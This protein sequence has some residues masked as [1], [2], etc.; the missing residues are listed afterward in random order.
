MKM[1][2]RWRIIG[3]VILVVSIGLGSLA[4]IS[5]VVI[6]NKTVDAVVDQSEVLVTQVSQTMTTF[7]S[8]YE[9]S[10]KNMSL[11][12]AVIEFAKADRTYGGEADT[13]YRAELS[14]FMS[15]FPDASSIYFADASMVTIEP[16]FDGVKDINATTRSWYE[17]SI[18]KPDEVQWTSPYIDKATGN[19]TI[20][21]SIAVKENNHIIGVLGVDILLDNLTGMVSTIELGYDGIPVIID[22]GGVAIVHPSQAGNDISEQDAVQKLIQAQENA[23]S[24]FTSIDNK[25]S[26]V[27]FS[28]IPKI[29]WNIGAIYDESKLNE[30]A[31]SIQKVIFII[32]VCILVITF[33]ALYIVI[34]RMVRPLYKLGTLMGRVANGDLTVKIDVKSHDEIGRLAHHFNNMITH[35]KVLIG[36]VQKS[37]IQVEERS[38]HLSALA[39]ESSASSSL[40]SQAVTEIAASASESSE[41]SDTVTV[42]SNSLGKTINLIQHQTNG[43]Q[44]TTVEANVMNLHGQQNIQELLTSFEHSKKDLHAM[45][46]I[47]ASLEQKVATINTVMDSITAIS[48]QTNLLALNA[49]IEAARAGEHGKGFAIVAEE[50]RKL[51]EQSAMATEQ[52]KETVTTLKTESISIS[53]QMNEMEQSFNKQ[54]SVVENTG[55]MF[56]TISAS[57]ATI[58]QAFTNLTTEIN[59]MIQ[60]KDEVINTIEE[61]SMITQ[62]VAATCEEVSASSD[63]QLGAIQSVAVASEELNSLSNDLASAAKQFTI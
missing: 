19:Y 54:G 27:A 36:V 44:Q 17:N 10:L 59:D 30:T 12:T 51:A 11:S 60:T 55:E 50:V 61:M 29:G 8:S 7:L 43:I 18:R 53:S 46:Q 13:N 9:Q 62:A 34:S 24:I 21:A 56:N 32:T 45:A 26:I 28:K 4:T 41:H 22:N 57:M 31:S 5:S 1:S 16:H 48:N 40:V 39:E 35:M 20:T 23:G 6:K 3:I 33:I 49:S 25:D 15:S 63:E 2:I 47:V 38:Q 37:S 58:E 52:V 42:I 14:N